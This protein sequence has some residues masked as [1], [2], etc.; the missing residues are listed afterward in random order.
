MQRV[1]EFLAIPGHE[2]L[3]DPVSIA[4]PSAPADRQIDR[5][6]ESDDVDER[7][8]A[9]GV[10]EIIESPGAFREGVLFQVSITMKLDGR[11]AAEIS[12][13][14]FADPGRPL[15]VDESEEVVRICTELAQ[16]VGGAAANA[17]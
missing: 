16:Q 4:R 5:A 2:L 10:V 17:S 14:D 7:R 6:Q 3:E 9:R 1:G 11:L 8:S 13:E 15:A 12:V